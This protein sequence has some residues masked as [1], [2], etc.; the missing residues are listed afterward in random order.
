MSLVSLGRT[1]L[2]EPFASAVRQEAYRLSQG[3]VRVTLVLEVQRRMATLNVHH[4]HLDRS[5]TMKDFVN[6]ARMDLYQR[7]QGRPSVSLVNVE[8]NQT[9]ADQHAQH[10]HPDNTQIPQLLEAIVI[11]VRTTKFLYLMEVASAP[12]AQKEL[13]GPLLPVAVFAIPASFQMAMAGVIHVLM[14]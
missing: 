12:C 9:M 1:R 11:L 13:V 10:A 2:T 5:R 8:C 7:L 3:L 6:N 4:V 14:D